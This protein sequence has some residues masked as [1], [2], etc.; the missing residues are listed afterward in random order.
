MALLLHC[1][2]R[3]PTPTTKQDRRPIGRI[4]AD[5][6]PKGEATEVASS[7]RC[8]GDRMGDHESAQ[9][10]EDRDAKVA[11]REDKVGP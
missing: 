4:E 2:D 3:K 9:R 5:G 6:S 7:D 11:G 10:E 8:S 1:A